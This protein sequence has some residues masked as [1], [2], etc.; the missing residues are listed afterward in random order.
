MADQYIDTTYIDAHLGT[1][2][3]TGATVSGVNITTQIEAATALV[4][5]YLTNSG[6]ATPSTTS[7]EN[8]KLATLGA[9]RVLLA[10]VPEA[11][12]PLPDGWDDHPA[13]I[14]YLGILSGELPVS[15]ALTNISAV[16]GWKASEH[17]STV[18]GAF[19]QRASR[20]EL[21]GY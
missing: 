16:G 19:T 17:R 1:N 7:D 6:Y 3:R 4:Q 15:H 20:D 11:T 5:G 10:S 13:R 14:A 2:Y 18:T 21:E 8:V 12:V 9:F